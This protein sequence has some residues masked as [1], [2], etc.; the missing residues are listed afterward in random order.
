[1]KAIW[2]MV[3]IPRSNYA[4]NMTYETVWNTEPA[5][6][7]NM[8]P[9]INWLKKFPIV[10]TWTYWSSQGEGYD[11]PTAKWWPGHPVCLLTSKCF[12]RESERERKRDDDEHLLSVS[13]CHHCRCVPPP[14]WTAWGVGGSSHSLSRAT[15]LVSFHWNEVLNRSMVYISRL[16]FR[17][18]IYTSI[19][20]SIDDRSID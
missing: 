18:Y 11:V 13:Q 15:A 2:P 12:E 1:M 3:P 5:L 10:S 16:I 6:W 17:L 20:A 8:G 19:D 9:S 4:M 14:E 7:Y